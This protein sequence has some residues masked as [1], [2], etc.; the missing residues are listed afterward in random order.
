MLQA[1]DIIAR[2]PDVVRNGLS[3][4]NDWADSN[5]DEEVL[6]KDYRPVVT[7]GSKRINRWLIARNNA[8]T[9]E[10]AEHTARWF[11][12]AYKHVDYMLKKPEQFFDIFNGDAERAHVKYAGIES[13]WTLEALTRM[14]GVALEAVTRELSEVPSLSVLPRGNGRA[15]YL[16][17]EP[18]LSGSFIGDSSKP[19][20][21]RAW[22]AARRELIFGGYFRH[23]S[24]ERA[25]EGVL[26]TVSCD[27]SVVTLQSFR[28]VSKLKDL[29]LLKPDLWRV[30]QQRDTI[31]GEQ[32]EQQ[33]QDAIQ[34]AQLSAENFHKYWDTMKT[35]VRSMVPNVTTTA[36]QFAQIPL[37]PEGTVSSRTWGIEVETVRA[38]FTSRPVGW[39]A[40]HDGS[41]NET[42]G[43]CDC[44]CDSCYDDSHCDVTDDE[45]YYSQEGES[46]EFVSPVLSHFNSNGL[47]QLCNDLPDDEDDTSPGIHVHV[48]AGDLT[49]TDVAR[50]LYSY[51]VIAPL[52]QPLYHRKTYGYC[53]EMASNNIAWW[54]GAARKHMTKTGSVPSPADICESQPAS[55]YQDVNVH[56]LYKHGT[57]E[58]RAMGPYYNYDHLVRWAWM[59]RE[60]VTVSKLGIEQREWSR[61]RSLTDV[62]NLLRKYGSEIPSDKPFVN[63]NTQAL[64]L[65]SSEE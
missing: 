17:S 36:E 61:C 57:V 25:S 51:S 38:Q 16:L 34:R 44:S 19:A 9:L 28:E 56:A 62:I 54:L 23:V 7:Y 50:L 64:A 27:D 48:G 59:V 32:I 6:D 24:V 11:I 41:L 55:R 53:N 10:K 33:R 13:L 40:V 22:F 35:R 43:T 52:L 2:H 46:Q 15:L 20:L 45:C 29:F 18:R 5:H 30:K 26:T 60:L 4:L 42:G 12:S 39:E 37:Q 3:Y 65:A 49:V 21:Q 47:R 1:S 63:V 8:D 58:F 14:F 31:L